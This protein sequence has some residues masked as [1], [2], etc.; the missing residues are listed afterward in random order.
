MEIAE[1]RRP[2]TP[3]VPLGG[4]QDRGVN[5]EMPARIISDIWRELIAAYIAITSEENAAYF[6]W[7]RSEGQLL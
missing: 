4:N 5:F 1:N 2:A 7:H 6:F 3:L